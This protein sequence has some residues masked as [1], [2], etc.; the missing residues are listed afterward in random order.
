MKAPF[1]WELIE[2]DIDSQ[3]CR[4]KVE[5]GWLVNHVIY[6][7][8]QESLVQM[9]TT[10]VPDPQH[11]WIIDKPQKGDVMEAMHGGNADA[12][13]FAQYR[14]HSCDKG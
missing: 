5:G 2:S 10:F 14:S 8:G 11:N 12:N 9:T 4:A 3:T 1:E 13:E 7:C 6:P